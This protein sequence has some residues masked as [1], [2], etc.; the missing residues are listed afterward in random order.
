MRDIRQ[1]FG[2]DFEKHLPTVSKKAVRELTRGLDNKTIPVSRFMNRK[3]QYEM[4]AE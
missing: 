2:V 1:I 4:E 3:S